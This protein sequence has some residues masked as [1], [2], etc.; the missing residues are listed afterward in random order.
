M[1]P[2]AQYFES[3]KLMCFECQ[4]RLLCWCIYWHPGSLH[5]KQVCWPLNAPSCA[6]LCGW[7]SVHVCMRWHPGLYTSA[8]TARL[9]KAKEGCGGTDGHMRVRKLPYY[10]PW[11]FLRMRKSGPV[12]ILMEPSGACILIFVSMFV[13]ITRGS[14]P[15]HDHSI[16]FNSFMW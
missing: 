14:M 15:S 9:G 2:I 11:V 12:H 10:V 8:T 5:K 7:Y 3:W 1:A 4:A 6:N 16:I 13:I